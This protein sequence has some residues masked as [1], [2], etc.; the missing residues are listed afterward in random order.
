MR[1]PP[2]LAPLADQGVIEEV[3]CPLM[4]GKEADVF[5]VV[6]RGERCVAKVYKDATQRSFKH[7]AEYEEGRRVRDSRRQRAM[8]RRSRYGRE[9]MEAAWR[10]AEVD[11]I[12]RLRDAGV[13]VPEPYDFVEGVLVMELIA[14]A[15]GRPAPRL[16]DVT[17]TRRE[18]RD[19]FN[20]LLREVVKMLCA[21]LVHGDL[22]DFNVL[23]G[24]DGPVIIDF[25][26]VADAAGNR[27]ARKLL[28]RDVKNLTRFLGRFDPALLNTRY[29][30]EMW[31][32][33][34]RGTLEPD[35]P[36]TGRFKGPTHKANVSSLLQE[37][38][39]IEREVRA[40]RAA[41]GL[42]PPGPARRPV[43]RAPEPEPEPEPDPDPTSP[44]KRRRRRRRRK[45]ASE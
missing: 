32:L 36:L 35:T 1:A 11:A 16:V 13:R 20:F 19:V 2:S 24:A 34:E 6:H 26:Q 42:E 21:G 10:N 30:P 44:K 28:L 14:D 9:M 38:E 43:R 7:R 3:I 12:Y 45:P 18:A 33:Y 22:S 41:L 23:M 5:L 25:P 17:F 39:D 8:T 4:S 29:G 27:N 40:R 15:E 31:D 37:L